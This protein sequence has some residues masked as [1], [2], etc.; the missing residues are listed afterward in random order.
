MGGQDQ[1]KALL[2]ASFD[3][4][5]ATSGTGAIIRETMG[6]FIAASCSNIPCVEDAAM[7]EARGLK[8]G[9]IGKQYRVQ[10][11]GDRV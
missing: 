1:E 11:V 6:S 7:A 8:D 4:N 9:L 10:Q 5:S 3:A 2:D